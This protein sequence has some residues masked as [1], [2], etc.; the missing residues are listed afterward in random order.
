MA[1]ALI[2][3][4]R[5]EVPRVEGEGSTAGLLHLRYRC[6]LVLDALFNRLSRESE[7]ENEA[8]GGRR[9]GTDALN[10]LGVYKYQGYVST[11]DGT[12]ASIGSM[13]SA[14]GDLLRVLAV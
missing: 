13:S 8:G 14:A 5:T 11:A 7:K 2:R 10:M 9:I 4:N 1:S 3:L 12:T 6:V